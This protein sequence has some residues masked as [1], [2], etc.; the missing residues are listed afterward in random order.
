MTSEPLK[1]IDCAGKALAIGD[2][3]RIVGVPELPKA[4]PDIRRCLRSLPICV[5][6]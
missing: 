3:V 5:A 1:A 2:R 6:K 4:H